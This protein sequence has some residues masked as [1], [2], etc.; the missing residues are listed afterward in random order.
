MNAALRALPG[1]ARLD[2]PY[3]GGPERPARDSLIALSPFAPLAVVVVVGST[4]CVFDPPA[5]GLPSG[6]DAH[7]TD[8]S[9]AEDSGMLD[10]KDGGTTD[11]A[12][13]TDGGDDQD[14]ASENRP[15]IALADS[16]T[17]AF[18]TAIEIPVLANDSDPDGDPLSLVSVDPPQHGSASITASARI[19]YTPAAGF[20][21]RDHFGYRV[22][23]GRGG[24]ATSTIDVFVTASP[25]VLLPMSAEINL[26]SHGQFTASG[27]VQPYSFSVSSGT[28]AIDPATGD[29]FSDGVPGSGRVL[30][31]DAIGQTASAT[32]SFGH[33]ALI[34]LGGVSGSGDQDEIF[35]SSDGVSWQTVGSLPTPLYL[36][37]AVVYNGRIWIAGGRNQ[38]FSASQ[39]LLSSTDGAHFST[40]G[41]LPVSLRGNQLVVFQQRLFLIGGRDGADV[42]HDEVWMSPDGMVWTLVGRLPEVRAYGAA[43]VH[44]GQIWYAGGSSPDVHDELW[45]SFDGTTWTPRGQLPEPRI[46]LGIAEHERR[47]W[48]FGGSQNAND[49]VTTVWQTTDGQSFTDA[50]D[51]PSNTGSASAV[52]WGGAI[53]LAGGGTRFLS[54]P[55]QAHDEVLTVA[56]AGNWVQQGALPGSRYNG[57]LVIFAP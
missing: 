19:A 35:R 46:Y 4:G 33:G 9:P 8:A 26:N 56:P 14:A 54:F 25:L 23:D 49:G 43:I 2:R 32:V 41:N 48:F 30:V 11:S 51:L 12:E 21:G 28:G 39:L 1:M 10:P 55:T 18:G 37:A 29:F 16:A 50:D 36:H 44:D 7:V 6:G 3:G 27:G 20:A 34:Y 5:A 17:T 42:Y 47:I 57:A 40:A 15:P 24:E 22:G 52:S 53:W 38:N 45:S 31:Q 13:R